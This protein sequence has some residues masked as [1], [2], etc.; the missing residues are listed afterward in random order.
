M[1]YGRRARR[2]YGRGVYRR[3]PSYRKTTVTRRRRKTTTRR[4]P[5]SAPTKMTGTGHGDKYVLA[6]ADPFDENVDGVKIPDANSQPSVPMK[7]EDTIDVTTSAGQTCAVVACNPTFYNQFVYQATASATSW[8]WQTAFGNSV[9]A[10]KLTQVRADHDMY[11]PVAHAVR[12]TSGLAP[13]AATGFVHVCVMAQALYSQTTWVYPTSVSEMQNV[14]GY[15]RIPLGRLTAEGLTI[16]N[17]PLDVTSQRYVD[18][19]ALPYRNA[20]SMEF[21]TGLQWCSVVVA[22]TGVP[23]TATPISIENILHL[24][25]IPRSSAIAQATPAAKYNVGALAGG[26]NAASKASVS[27]LDSEKPARKASAINHALSGI[28][29]ASG[30]MMRLSQLPGIRRTPG[31]GLSGYMAAQSD[32]TMASAGGIRNFVSSS[33]G[34]FV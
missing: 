34:S 33:K 23:A 29:S 9:H 3:R 28:Q 2:S 15:K 31:R 30:G 27:H 24:E 14:P 19:D 5:V 22:V 11:R 26:S 10:A 6:L 1:A 12:I 17:R 8:T 32:A 25:C 21:H 4:L 20:D 16:V 13:T 18:T 7:L